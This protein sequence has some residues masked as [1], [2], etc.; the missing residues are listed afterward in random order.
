MKSLQIKV[1]VVLIN[2][3]LDGCFKLK[4]QKLILN[5]FK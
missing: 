2:T 3:I 5:I 1:D 4:Q